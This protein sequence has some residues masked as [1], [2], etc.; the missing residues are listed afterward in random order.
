[1]LTGAGTTLLGLAFALV[2]TRTG[3][4]AKRLLRVLTVLP[5][6]T[7]PFVVGLA[8]I[9]LFG[10]S[11]TV[12]QFLARRSASRPGAGSTACRAC[13]SRRRWPS[14]RSPSWS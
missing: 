2:V 4:R 13:G 3:F 8:I 10:R 14:R 1:M 6:I 12:T 7:P 5:I 11:G 9:L